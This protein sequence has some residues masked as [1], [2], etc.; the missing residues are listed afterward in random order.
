MQNE[1]RVLLIHRRTGTSHCPRHWGSR[2]AW[3]S[4]RVPASRCPQVLLHPEGKQ[5]GCPKLGLW[6]LTG[7]H[8]PKV[9][10]LKRL[11][12]REERPSPRRVQALAGTPR[13]RV[14]GENRGCILL[15]SP[16]SDHGWPGGLCC[17]CA[18]SP[19]VSAAGAGTRVLPPHHPTL[20]SSLPGDTALNTPMPQ[21]QTLGAV[22][23]APAHSAVNTP[24]QLM[25]LKL[26]RV[27]PAYQVMFA[28]QL[29]ENIQT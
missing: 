8:R 27:L 13:F 5:A 18:A 28:V 9:S 2:K 26:H 4:R 6:S 21:Q 11:Q 1:T 17:P 15:C 25:N 12:G 14:M 10:V 3:A 7:T 19:G 24:N 22:V 29:Y 20:W 16:S 23:H